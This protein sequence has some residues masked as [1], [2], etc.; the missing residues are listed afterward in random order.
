MRDLKFIVLGF[1]A[2]IT[3]VQ[4]EA[5]L[6][7][8][9]EAPSLSKAFEAA[10]P[11]Q[12]EMAAEFMALILDPFYIPMAKKYADLA[13]ILGTAKSDALTISDA[14]QG[15][16]PAEREQ[17]GE[18]M[19]SVLDPVYMAMFYGPNKF[20]NPSNLGKLLSG[21]EG[22]DPEDPEYYKDPFFSSAE[23]TKKKGGFFA[24]VKRCKEIYA[25]GDL[26]NSWSK[27]EEKKCG[28][29]WTLL[30]EAGHWKR[31]IAGYDQ[32]E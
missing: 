23:K 26:L 32:W 5:T 8:N 25:A 18:I 10:S 17:A 12:R 2:V 24:E 4:S 14:L 29:I 27:A 11:V 22:K 9:I 16:S 30:M 15:A 20:A 28:D 6:K 13:R 19:A 7:D 3:T 21:D 1:L 31:E